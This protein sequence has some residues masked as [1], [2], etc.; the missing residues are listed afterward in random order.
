MER[1][2]FMALV[3]GSLLAAPLAAE[4]QKGKVWRIGVISV[5]R[6]AGEEAFFERLRDLGYVEG[7]NLV[8]E[9]RYSEGRAERF[10]EFAAELVRLKVHIII[11]STT[12]AALA[13]KSATKTI[14]IVF[15][16]AI[17]PVGPGVVASLARPGGNITGLTTQA[18]DLVAKRLQFLKE[19]IPRLS[20]IAV[21]WNAANPANARPW[22]EAQ[23]AA[24]ALRVTLQSQAVRGPTDFERVFAAMARERPEGLLLIVDGLTAQ[25]GK[26]IVDFVTQKRIPSMLELP[27]LTVAGG[28]MS[29]GPS[30]V[31][32]WARAAVL[33]DKILKGA[34]PADL[35]VEQPS[36]FELIINL[37]T[38]KALGLTIPQSLLQRADEVVQ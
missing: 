14:P 20:R 33:V 15:P 31:D 22:R 24:R 8:T 27:E 7:Q 6:R 28:L 4:A 2:T 25:H 30:T 12:P 29:Y 11:V 32:L 34:K 9:R 19:A 3:S 13:I 5:T 23:D 35:P 16:T 21:L 38:A 10:P 36:K 26:Q 17:D 18:P 1:R 37:R